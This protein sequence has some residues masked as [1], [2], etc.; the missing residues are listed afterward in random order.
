MNSHFIVKVVKRSILA[1]PCS[2][3]EKKGCNPEIIPHSVVKVLKCVGFGRIVLERRARRLQSRNN[4]HS[5]VQVIK[6]NILAVYNRK[7]IH[8]L[9]AIKRNIWE[10][11]VLQRRTRILKSKNNSH[12][13]SKGD[14]L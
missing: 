11:I 5:I 7:L 8:I 13:I 3:S 2:N 9:K 14:K 12:S 6:C 1:H 4:P 10:R